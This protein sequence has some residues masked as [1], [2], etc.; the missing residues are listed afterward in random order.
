MPLFL[1]Q[2][3]IIYK[4]MSNLKYVDFINEPEVDKLLK[5]FNKEFMKHVVKH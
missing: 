5:S 3:I 4:Y 1:Q 2:G